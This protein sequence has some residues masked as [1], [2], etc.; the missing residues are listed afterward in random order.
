M[1]PA[2]GKQEVWHRSEN[3]SHTQYKLHTKNQIKSRYLFTE[4]FMFLTFKLLQKILGRQTRVKF[5]IINHAIAEK[6]NDDTF[7]CSRCHRTFQ[8]IRHVASILS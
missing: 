6:C 5:C 3:R 7:S 1:L 4:I 8:C 2:V